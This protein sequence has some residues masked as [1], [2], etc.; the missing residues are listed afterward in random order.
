MQENE[1]W[2]AQEEQGTAAA[3]FLSGTYGVPI[4]ISYLPAEL[5]IHQ[6]VL[7]VSCCVETLPVQQEKKV[8]LLTSKV[9][10]NFS[11]PPAKWEPQSLVQM[12][13]PPCLWL[14]EPWSLCHA[15]LA[16]Q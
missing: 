12:L 9:V 8:L 10:G 6:V 5:G 15:A 3:S 11:V 7:F 14:H 2:S 4:I 13:T 1:G 16:Q